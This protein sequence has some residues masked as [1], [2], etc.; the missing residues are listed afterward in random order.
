MKL[1]RT[2]NVPPEVTFQRVP[3]LLAPSVEQVPYMFPL[4]SKLTVPKGSC[5][6]V[7]YEK[8]CKTLNAP[9][10][11]SSQR[12]PPFLVPPLEFVPYMLPLLSK[13][14]VENSGFEPSEARVKLRR[15]LKVCAFTCENDT[16]SS[17][18]ARANMRRRNVNNCGGGLKLGAAI[19]LV[20]IPDLFVRAKSTAP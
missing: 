9:P 7:A 5:P 20:E 10:E 17:R 14:T 19:C 1:R 13:A 4:L 8:L 2:V 11:L 3:P 12:V 6:S 16:P 15:T 18:I